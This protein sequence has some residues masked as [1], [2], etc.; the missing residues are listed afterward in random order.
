VL[1]ACFFRDIVT[2][3]PPVG[4][5]VYFLR[6]IFVEFLQFCARLKK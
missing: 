2:L 5:G 1:V 6:I 4:V 3:L